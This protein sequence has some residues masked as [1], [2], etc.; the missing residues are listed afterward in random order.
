LY[1]VGS[2]FFATSF[3]RALSGGDFGQLAKESYSRTLQAAS[4]SVRYAIC[5]TT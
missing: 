2:L 3:F 1:I 4:S 5:W